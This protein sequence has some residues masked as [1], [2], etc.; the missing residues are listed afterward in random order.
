MK[1]H[2][3]VLHHSRHASNLRP[4]RKGCHACHVDQSRSPSA[5]PQNE[6]HHRN[7]PCTMRIHLG[8]MHLPRMNT[9]LTFPR[10]PHIPIRTR[11]VAGTAA[12]SVWTTISHIVAHPPN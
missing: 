4:T 5:H 10:A 7:F 2:L 3:L 11:L 6:A 1:R 12:L 8:L 9:P